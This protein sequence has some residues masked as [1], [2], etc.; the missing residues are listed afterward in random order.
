MREYGS[1]GQF[2]KQISE[3]ASEVR[4]IPLT[5]KNVKSEPV[6]NGGEEEWQLEGQMTIYDFAS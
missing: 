4:R 1:E 3:V 6:D 5:K 2:S